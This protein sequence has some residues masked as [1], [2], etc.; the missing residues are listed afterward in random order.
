MTYSASPEP[1]AMDDGRQLMTEF[2]A[3]RWLSDWIWKNGTGDFPIP[4]EVQ[5]L[6]AKALTAYANL[7]VP[8]AAPGEGEKS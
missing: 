3:R 6:Y 2:Q 7:G 5:A 1:A 8:L 4:S